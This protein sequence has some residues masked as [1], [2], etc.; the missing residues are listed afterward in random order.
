MPKD[1]VN[2][3]GPGNYSPEKVFKSNGRAVIGRQTLDILDYKYHKRERSLVPEPG[4][5]GRFSDFGNT[6]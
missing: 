1:R 5:Y 3:P 6:L 2:L 4:T